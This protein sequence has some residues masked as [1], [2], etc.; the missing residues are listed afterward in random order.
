M[1]IAQISTLATPVRAGFSGSVEG[2]VW[3]LTKEL[4]ELGHEVTV[5]GAAGSETSGEFVATLPGPY[6]LDGSPDDWQLCEW[7]NLCRAVERSDGFDIIHSHAYLWGI[8]LNPFA[9]APMVHTMHVVP[10]DD[11][12]RLW[13]LSPDSSV[14]A[15]SDY[16]WSSFPE[17][18]LAGRVYH[19]V[20]VSEFPFQPEPDD[21]VCY[22]GQFFPG[23]GPLAAI[24]A[25][26]N[27]GLKL[28]LA[29][30]TNG[31]FH[32]HVEPLVDG[33]QIEYTGYVSGQEKAK[34]L[35]GAKALLYPM[36]YPEPFG[37]VQIEAMMC[38]TPVAA[39]NVGA[40]SEIIDQGVTGF[41]AETAEQFEQAIVQSFM[42]DRQRVRRTAETRFTAKRMALEYLQIY[43]QVLGE[44]FD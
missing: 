29:G 25:A 41:Y 31:Y 28:L 24:A 37:L 32:K 9:R 8:P 3:L 17:L 26:R 39:I 38:G 40:V 33:R 14:T 11:S 10:G 19:G 30:P 2:L 6:C 34:L 18:K 15:I 43:Q 20:D 7:I 22:L 12:A 27:L 23:K 1:R 44:R 4:T 16:Q 35:G 5:F 21:Y 13:A 36:Q 42:L